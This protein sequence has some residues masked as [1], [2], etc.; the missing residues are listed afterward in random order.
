[1]IESDHSQVFCD[2]HLASMQME[3][4]TFVIFPSD[5]WESYFMHCTIEG[6][7]RHFNTLHGYVDIRDRQ[8]VGA[9]RKIQGCSKRAEHGGSVAIVE[10]VEGEPLWRCVYNDCTA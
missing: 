7:T 6:C 5:A 8:I 1:M 10:I 3:K 4:H 9:S 2:I